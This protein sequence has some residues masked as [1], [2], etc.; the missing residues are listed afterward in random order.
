MWFHHVPWDHRMR[1]G[2]PFWDE[3]VYRYQTGVQYVTWLRETWDSLEPHIDARRFAEVDAKLALHEADAASW[4]DVSVNYWREFSGRPNPVDDGPLSIKI[5]VGGRTV[6]GFDMSASSYP[7]PVAAG[8]SPAITKVI[9]AQR[10]VRYRILSQADQVP[11]Q[12]V[13]KVTKDTSFGPV[14]K[15]YTFNLV[16][17]TTLKSLTAGGTE[18][19]SPGVLA[20]RALLPPDAGDVTAVAAAA[21]DPAATVTVEQATT[22]TGQA[23]VTVHNG[24]A[25]AT[26]TVDFD[27]TLTGSDG[28][29]ADV[30]G[31]Q[32][33]WVRQDD[34]AWRLSGGSL[35]VAARTG[36]LQENVNTAR[37]IALQDVN[38]DWTAESRLAFS[39]PLA[40]NNEQGGVIAYADDDNYVKLAW[41]MADV[42]AP[43]NK[44]RLVLVGEQNGVVTTTQ[45][46]GAEA[47]RLVGDNGAIWL[48]LKKTGTTYRAYYSTD[49][50][51]YKFMGATTMTA[52]PTG[53]G[54]FAFNRAGT[55]TDLDVAFDHF[56]I[57]SHGAPVG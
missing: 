32:W 45:V 47:Q 43:I 48:R 21:T 2:T 3:L 56:T 4:R 20:Y 37:N 35:V 22:P 6:G 13:V 24:G 29:D 31:P 8:G 7:I 23:K 16:P 55:A 34:S 11:G 9:P 54:L 14:V 40:A 18:L 25:T 1:D 36:D 52:A 28:F 39:R 27:A 50:N 33:R 46:T 17:D 38:G 44:R 12:A 15:N 57:E 42:S 5:V 26:Y 19:V 51:V 49:G 41:E 30:L 53:A 10:G